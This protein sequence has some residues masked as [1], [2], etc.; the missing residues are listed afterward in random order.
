LNEFEKLNKFAKKLKRMPRGVAQQIAKKAAPDLTSRTKS[1]FD[2][3]RT[4]YNDA[5]PLG[6][7]GNAVSLV[8]S[9]DLAK[10]LLFKSIGTIVRAVLGLPYAKYLIR[11]G[12][13][14]GGA[15]IPTEWSAALRKHCE[16][17]AKAFIAV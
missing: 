5:R 15:K 17:E 4:V 2:S 16:Q 11:F 7:R 14:P 3:G 8:K 12:I 9:G 13:I 1:A 6:S 10:T